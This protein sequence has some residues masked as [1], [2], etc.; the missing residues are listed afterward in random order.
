MLAFMVFL[1]LL[2]YS[3]IRAPGQLRQAYAAWDTGILLVEYLKAHDDQWPKSWDDL[4]TVMDG[5]TECDFFLRGRG[6]LDRDYAVSLREKVAI[7]WNFD[8]KSPG[9]TQPVTRQDGQPFPV[10][11]QGADPNKMIRDHLHSRS[12]PAR[13]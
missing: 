5:K 10:K 4:L 13:D 1:C 3:A 6:S 7:D 2:V 9:Q 12:P 8:P 11:W